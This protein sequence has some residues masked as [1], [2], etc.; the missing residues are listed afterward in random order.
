M[1]CDLVRAEQSRKQ[2]W[3]DISF[4]TVPK[5]KITLIK[6]DDFLYGFS[7]PF[8]QLCRATVQLAISLLGT[9]INSL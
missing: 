9:C 5:S 2:Q 4:I 7:L 6:L 8:P 3:I 1:A